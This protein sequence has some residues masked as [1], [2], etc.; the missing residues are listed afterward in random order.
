MFK[1]LL[2]LLLT[3]LLLCG[4]T[5]QSTW[6]AEASPAPEIL[7][8]AEITVPNEAA[9]NDGMPHGLILMTQSKRRELISFPN[10]YPNTLLQIFVVDPNTGE[11]TFWSQFT[12]PNSNIN[13]G[14]VLVGNTHSQFNSNYTKLAAE[15]PKAGIGEFGQDICHAGWIDQSGEFFDVSVALG[16][17]HTNTIG[18][19]DTGDYFYFLT[20]RKFKAS[21]GRL[22]V[23]F[24]LCCGTEEDIK[25]GKYQRL[26]ESQELNR[27]EDGHRCYA[28]SKELF[29]GLQLYSGGN[30]ELPATDYAEP[31]KNIIIAD[32]LP[33]SG[34]SHLKAFQV[35]GYTSVLFDSTTGTLIHYLPDSYNTDGKS[36]W[37]GVLSPD[38]TTVAYLTVPGTQG[39]VSLEF[40]NIS[41]F[42][43]SGC[44]PAMRGTPTKLELPEG[45]IQQA[46]WN[47]YTYVTENPSCILLDWR[48]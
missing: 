27:I 22:G 8:S 21:D 14:Y 25:N 46:N 41:Q 42:L 28:Y 37:G 26:W 31:S 9:V 23:Y 18:F 7:P 34:Y 47:V 24:V 10:P 45:P 6:A 32:Y 35:K 11:Q 43:A 17:E 19:S 30:W 4:S 5:S 33:K 38:G 12:E 16:L 13:I 3:A 15:Y 36:E 20:Y 39:K 1:K 2:S 29:G 44:N 40:T 48:E